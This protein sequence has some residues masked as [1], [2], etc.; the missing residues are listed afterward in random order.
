MGV[1]GC[2]DKRWGKGRCRYGKEGDTGGKDESMRRRELSGEDVIARRE[3]L[4]NS[5]DVER[6]SVRNSVA[7]NVV[8]LRRYVQPLT[9]AS[10]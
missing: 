9:S 5:E 6:K 3:N 8:V 2:Y 1:E 10:T 4:D 7:E